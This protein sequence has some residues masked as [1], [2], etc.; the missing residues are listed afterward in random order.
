MITEYTLLNNGEPAT[1]GEVEQ[2][3]LFIHNKFLYVKTEELKLER[4]TTN[5]TRI[6]SGMGFCFEDDVEVQLVE[7]ITIEFGGQYDN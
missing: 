5:A 2:G 4:L 1:F 6:V 7:N 3:K